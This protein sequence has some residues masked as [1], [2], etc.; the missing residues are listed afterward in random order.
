MYTYIHVYIHTHMQT[1]IHACMHACR[2]RYCSG[3]ARRTFFDARRIYFDNCVSQHLS[4][5]GSSPA[6]SLGRDS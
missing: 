1:Y 2:S 5:A 6:G 3:Y 4:R